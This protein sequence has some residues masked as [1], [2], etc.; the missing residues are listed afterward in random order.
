MFTHAKLVLQSY[1]PLKLEKGMWFIATHNGQVSIYELGYTIY[2]DEQM[3][4]FLQLNGYP[5]E[6][7]LYIQGNP[8]IPDETFVI[9][10][11]EQ[12]GWFDED[13]ESDEMHDITIKE[14]NNILDNDGWCEI[15]VEEEHLDD[16]EAQEDYINI[17]PVLLENKV[18]IR[19]IFDDDDDEDYEE[20][21]EEDE[22]DKEFDPADHYCDMCRGTGEGSYDGSRCSFC[23]GSGINYDGSGGDYDDDRDYYH[24]SHYDY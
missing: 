12:I 23:K 18:T 20:E 15:E 24:Y 2:S 3:E 17:L 10:T 1:K 16:D 14:I 19:Y 22:E 11:P 5:V 13:E 4:T 8:N 7:Y 6:P 21:E 9:A